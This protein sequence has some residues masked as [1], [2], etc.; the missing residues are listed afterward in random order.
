[1]C[2]VVEAACAAVEAPGGQ[3]ADADGEVWFPAWSAWAAVEAAIIWLADADG[4]ASFWAFS[5]QEWV[6]E[7]V[8]EEHI[9]RAGIGILVRVCDALEGKARVRR[10][11][12]VSE[13][14]V[15]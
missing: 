3:E 11:D 6:A 8:L 9:G 10:E 5:G 12:A 13:P 7:G 14:K 4:E 2:V 1:M 15:D